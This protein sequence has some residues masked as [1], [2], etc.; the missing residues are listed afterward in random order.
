MAAKTADEYRYDIEDY[1]AAREWYRRRKRDGIATDADSRKVDECR[2]LA[3][4]ARTA[5]VTA[6]GFDALDRSFHAGL[7]SDIS[8][9][10]G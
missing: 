4:T 8:H 9:V 6:A 3:V 2:K 10:T 7:A 5:G 1:I